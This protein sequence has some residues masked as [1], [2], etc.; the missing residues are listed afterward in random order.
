MMEKHK[1]FVIN[2]IPDAS[3]AIPTV[4]L[5]PLIRTFLRFKQRPT[6]SLSFLC[7]VLS[8]AS[9]QGDKGSNKKGE[10]QNI[11]TSLELNSA[12]KV[13]TSG[14]QILHHVTEPN[15]FLG[16][17]KYTK[18]LMVIDESGS[19]LNK[20]NVIGNGPEEVGNAFESALFLNK[21]QIAV[22]SQ[23]GIWVYDLDFN[24]LIKLPVHFT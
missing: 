11:T 3:K 20:K 16:Y 15:R 6:L 24:F 5:L 14:V 1:S 7:L 2:S 18:S 21:D 12:L 9:C 4:S 23:K 10:H 17:N 19:I 22:S 13:N 8:L